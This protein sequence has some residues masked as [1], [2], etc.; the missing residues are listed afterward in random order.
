[1]AGAKN[2]AICLLL[3]RFL[4]SPPYICFSGSNVDI[5]VLLKPAINTSFCTDTITGVEKKATTCE[6]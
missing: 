5:V 1:M 3:W 6:L 4:G 2:V